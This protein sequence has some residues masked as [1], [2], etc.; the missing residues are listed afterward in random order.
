M[1]LADVSSLLDKLNLKLKP[2]IITKKFNEVAGNDRTL[3]YEGFQV[4]LDRLHVNPEIEGAL[5]T[6]LTALF[7]SLFILNFEQFCNN[8][9]NI[10]SE[11]FQKFAPLQAG[12]SANQFLDS[13]LKPIQGEKEMKVED[14]QKI[15]EFCEKGSGGNSI[16][17][18]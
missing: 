1:A 14:A 8:N 12:M 9:K 17:L 4:F 18:I 3:D 6:V 16:G 11:L 7:H 5:L 13:F 15:I 2:E 10:F